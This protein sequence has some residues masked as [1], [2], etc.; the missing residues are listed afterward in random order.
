MNILSM[1]KI[2]SGKRI[3][4]ILMGVFLLLCFTQESHA[5]L[6]FRKFGG[7][8]DVGWAG[9]SSQ[10]NNN[11]SYGFATNLHVYYAPNDRLKI[12]IQT[13][14]SSIFSGASDTTSTYNLWFISTYSP[15][16]WYS[17]TTGRI[18]PYVA[19]GT[20]VSRVREKN[21]KDANN[22]T[23]LGERRWGLDIQPEVGVQAYF[24]F[25]AW[26]YHLGSRTP[27]DPAYNV[28]QENILSSHYQVVLGVRYT[29]GGFNQ[30]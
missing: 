14:R 25:L 23:V 11:G 9:A 13:D 26:R 4:N 16:I 21:N 12:G 15:K 10:F 24:A 3:L 30:D 27:K 6:E 7:G 5:Q 8:L 22:Q 17:F 19:L 29:I 20:G 18:Q 1:K 2:I 28:G